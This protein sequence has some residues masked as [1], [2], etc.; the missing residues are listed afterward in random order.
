VGASR[1]ATATVCYLRDSRSRRPGGT[2]TK[3]VSPTESRPAAG[4]YYGGHH[5]ACSLWT[6]HLP[7]PVH[8]ASAGT[9]KTF[10]LSNRFLELLRHDVPHDRI[11]ATTFTRK[12][13]GEI[14]DR[15]I[16][17]LA[18]ARR[19][20][21]N[22]GNWPNTPVRRTCPARLVCGCWRRDAPLA[23]LAGEYLGQFLRPNRAQL[24]LGIGP[25][26]RLANRRGW[27][28]AACGPR[29]SPRSSPRTIRPSCG[30]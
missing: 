23:S 15:V 16:L 10:Q 25:A 27:D 21:R 4:T 3:D 26:A 11:L 8:S 22:A 12:A 30:R 24:Q 5:H 18:E 20:R 2:W 28:D 14:L 19:A 29:P 6:P 1:R 7:S 13:A 17:R 9:G